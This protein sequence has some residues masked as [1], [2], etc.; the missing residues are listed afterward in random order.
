MEELQLKYVEIIFD[1]QTPQNVGTEINIL[2]KVDSQIGNLE[3]KFIV[4]KGGIWNTI[5]EFSENNECAWKPK[6]EGE[7]MVMVQGREKDGRKP[8]DYLAK[9]DYSIVR[10]EAINIMHEEVSIEKAVNE[11]NEKID[12]KD[13][14]DN[15]DLLRIKKEDFTEN[16][17]ELKKTI[18]NAEDNVVFFDVKELLKEEKETLVVANDD[19]GEIAFSEDGK[20]NNNL[21]IEL[22]ENKDKKI[23][24]K[25]NKGEILHEVILE[26]NNV[27]SEE[28]KD[29]NDR[30]VSVIKE[31]II[32]KEEVV[33]GE[34]C[35]IEVKSNDTNGYLY[36]FYI[37][38][39]KDWDIVRDYDTSNILKYTA[40]EAGEKEFL[41]QCKR[42]ESTESFEDYRT[43]KVNVKNIRKIEITNFK[44]LSKSLIVGE[45]LE[46]VVQTNLQAEA[47]EKDEI[48][49]LYKFYKIYKDGKSVCIQDYSTKSDVYYK[50]M[51]NGTYRILCL[52]KSILSNKEYDD[53]AILVYTVKPYKDIK[54]N[55]FVADLNSPQASETDIKFTSEV[56]G[57]NNILYKYKVKGPIE[58]DTG[59]IDKDEFIWKP[60]EAGEY[61][62]IL[63]VKDLN[64][65]G[66]YEDTRKIAFTIEKKGKKLVK[67]LDVV[68]D[69]EKK[70]II[71]EP[72]NIMVNGEGGTRLQYSFIIRKDSRKLEGVDYNKSNWINFIPKQ[73]GEY[74]VEIMLKD[75]YSN[76]PYDAQTVIHLKAMEYVPGEI[77]YIILPFK[78]THLIGETIEFECII[79]NTQNVVVKYE[80]K[81]NGNSVE[82]TEFSKNKKLRFVPKIAGKYTIEVYAKNLKCKGE[83]DSKKQV[84]LY[85]SEAPPV[86]ETKIITNKVEGDINEELT[87]EVISRG[88]KDVCYEFYLMENNEW[89]KVQAYSRKHYYSF[90]P[91]IS[92]KYKILALAKSYYKKGSYEDYDQIVFYVKGLKK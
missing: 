85:V 69:K 23:N 81:I 60:M 63:Y 45:K 66:E 36:R 44:C 22:A 11:G 50:E 43:I 54:I 55:S 2:S 80:T 64:Y 1:K 83:Y 38:R 88:G 74:E 26:K 39:Y 73:A 16:K 19:C 84:S 17:I 75:K 5:Q 49:L 72:V 67:I 62:I 86:I 27:L 34:K 21:K 70:I 53:R 90:I 89:K 24:V 56:Q 59:F 47:S 71:G 52:V 12:F 14:V 25:N 87:F 68:I 37:K 6:R 10:G 29:N 61:E 65:K 20:R 33:I 46:F 9:E 48:I 8:L 91:F 13:I 42:M 82:Q 40:T 41:I 78:E 35:S 51:E 15:D 32:D 3:Y 92:G 28:S 58:E 30:E 77:D 4:G 31:I 18:N 76:K 57:G 7:Y 79:Q